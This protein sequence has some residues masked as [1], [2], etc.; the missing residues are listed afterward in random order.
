MWTYS[1]LQA[2]GMEVRKIE[3]YEDNKSTIALVKKDRKDGQTKHIDV[4]HKFIGEV[5]KNKPYDLKWIA[6]DEQIA[7]IFTKPLGKI[8]FLKFREL[9]GLKKINLVGEC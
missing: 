7:D 9:L 4:Q 5:I 3:L 6:T 8:K 1:F 2:I